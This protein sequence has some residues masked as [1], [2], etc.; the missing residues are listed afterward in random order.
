MKKIK[1][2]VFLII[3]ILLFSSFIIF[4]R[5][6]KPVVFKRV[7]SVIRPV[8]YNYQ[9]TISIADSRNEIKLVTAKQY[10]DFIN[11]MDGRDGNFIQISTYEVI[12]GIDFSEGENAKV[13][14]LSEENTKIGSDITIR[15]FELL[16]DANTDYTKPLEAVYRRKALEYACQNKIL[17]K[18]KKQAEEALPKLTT[19][20]NDF[21]TEDNKFELE[22]PYLPLKL[23]LVKDFFDDNFEI[24]ESNKSLGFQRD[25][26]ILK[27]KNESNPEWKIR[28]GDTGMTYTGSFTNFYK[29]ILNTNIKENA[30]S[31]NNV[32]QLYRYFDSQHPDEKIC[33]SYASDYYRTFFILSGS[34]IY[35]I[36]SFM[37]D[38]SQL[39]ENTLINQIAPVMLYIASSV[40]PSQTEKPGSYSY[41]QYIKQFTETG[42][43]IK[44][45]E[46]QSNY[47]IAV[48]SL[49][50]KNPVRNESR[51]SAEEKLFISRN[52]VN[53]KEEDVFITG[54]SNF[55][56]FTQK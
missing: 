14:I 42:N 17:E 38:E 40:R 9:T 13:K 11:V 12:A 10:I 52:L 19:D 32:V 7:M 47:D 45:D 3:S 41:R 54:D 27:Y 25:S 48:K 6:T 21:V 23:E 20:E 5:M 29:N 34:R 53:Q 33:L 56:Y 15:N 4:I 50:E 24:D 18:A 30:A 22:L 36:D 1:S 46:N 39:D 26:L 16:D 44:K 35:Y 37:D 8:E 51:R 2:Y 31:K 55:D 28:F 43:A 49:L